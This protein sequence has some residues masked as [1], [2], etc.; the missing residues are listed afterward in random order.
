M[1]KRLIWI[2]ITALLTYG[3]LM[4]K[5]WETSGQPLTVANKSELQKRQTKVKQEQVHQGN[6]VL[7]NLDNPVSESG[8]K[9]NIMLAEHFRETT[10]ALADHELRLSERAAE[11]L[12]EMME[13]ARKDGV[14]NF[15]INS[16]YRTLADQEKLY[17]EQGA[18]L[19]MPAGRSEHNLGL[20]VDIGSLQGK[21]NVT[22]EGRWLGENAWKYGFILRYPEGKTDVTGI[23]FEPWHFRYVGLPHSAVMQQQNMVFEEYL[24]YLKQMKSIQTTVDGKTYQIEYYP[25]QEQTEIPLPVNRSYELSGNNRDGIIVTISMEG[26]AS[27]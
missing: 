9:D 20:S 18:E 22:K 24:D 4:G 1:D 8:T 7:V 13:A 14:D 11:P 12:L 5:P 21:M 2:A 23:Q 19:A 27:R 26:G 17:T 25:V 3:V 16:G 10:I 15:I 6:L